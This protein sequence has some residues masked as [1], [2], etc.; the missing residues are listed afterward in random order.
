M[1]AVIVL[2]VAGADHDVAD[3]ERRIEAACD[4]AQQQRPTVETVEQQRGRDPGIDLARA[5]FD[6]HGVA[7]GDLALPEAQ[8][9]E[10]PGQAAGLAGAVREVHELLGQSRYDA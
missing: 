3:P 4:A 8:A 9:A 2:H 5:R 10:D 6:E 1:G 7:A